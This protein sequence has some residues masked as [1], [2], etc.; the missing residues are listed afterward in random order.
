[1]VFVALG[2]VLLSALSPAQ[3]RVLGFGV[4]VFDSA[5]PEIQDAVHVACGDYHSLVLRRNGEVLAWGDNRFGQCDVPAFAPGLVPIEVAAGSAHSLVL[6]SD[7]SVIAWGDDSFGQSDVPASPPGVR[8]VQIDAEGDMNVALRSDSVVVAWGDNRLGQCNVPPAPSGTTYAQ[9]SAGG[10]H[11]IALCANGTIVAWGDN[12]YGQSTPPPV[13]IGATPVKVAAGRYSSVALYSSGQYRAWGF[14]YL[15]IIYGVYNSPWFATYSN[16]DTTGDMVIAAETNGELHLMRDTGYDFVSLARP[17]VTFTDVAVGLHHALGCRSDGSLAVVHSTYFASPGLYGQNG[18]RPLQSGL[19]CLDLSLGSYHNLAL[20]SDGSVDA[21]GGAAASAVPR[22]LDGRPFTAFTAGDEFTVGLLDDGRVVP[23]GSNAFGQ[24]NPPPLPGGI[25][26]SALA[27][28]KNHVVALRSDSSVVG[29]GD[30]RLGQC[31]APS[32]PPGT[33]YIGV[34]AGGDHSAALRTDGVL[35]LWGDNRYG[36]S[37]APSPP[38]GLDC[39]AAALGDYHTLALWSDGTIA[40]FG[41]NWFGQCNVPPLPAGVTYVG[42]AAGSYHSIGLRSDGTAVAWGDDSF[43]QCG[44]PAPPPGTAIVQV[45]AHGDRS[46]VRCGPSS[47]Y[48]V[49]ATGCAGSMAAARL[50]PRSLPG[51]G[52]TL[53]VDLIG[54]P[55]NA[56][57]LVTGLGNRQSSLGPLPLSLGSIGMPGCTAYVA[58]QSLTLVLG[59]AARARIALPLPYAESLLGKR[60]YQQAIVL[61]PA[62]NA[63]GAVMSDAAAAVIGG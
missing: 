36:Q 58:D 20:L 60:F 38:A 10:D 19:R 46:A 2:A 50:V 25:V 52:E 42:V 54:L 27:A 47:S 7:G 9:V 16:L 23:F 51:I 62:V 29:W 55:A 30:N 48:A 53:R 35:V 37:T 5:I 18:P 41:N 31:I 4:Q 11:G 17:G 32:P 59:A 8:Y 49:F 56:A 13:L 45:V 3:S 26:Y 43:G 24:L 1:M 57:V 28:G 21:W 34:A 33:R 40:A 15:P 61:D 44:V 6:F 14:R 22:Q 12:T 39:I 63:L